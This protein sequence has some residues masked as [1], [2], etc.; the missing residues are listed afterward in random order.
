MKQEVRFNA[1][2]AHSSVH[3]MPGMWRHPRDTSLEHKTIEYWQKLARVLENG[4]FDAIF[5]ADAIGVN[6]VHGG[7]LDTAIRYGLRLPRHDPW[8]L[9]PA[10]AAVTEH[11][12]FGITGTLSYEEPYLF[13]RK[14]STLDHLTR[15]RIAWN[16]VTGYLESG[17]KAMGRTGMMGHD[18][19][20]DIAD[21]F[22]DVV[23][24]LWE[25]SWEDG[26]LKADRATGMFSDPSKVHR[27]SHKGQYYTMDGTHMVDP[28]P[29]RTPV[30]YQAGASGRGRRFAAAHAESVFMIGQT[31]ESLAEI[32]TDV[33]G[34]AANLGR[35]PME[36]SFL[37][38]AIIIVGETEAAA[39]AK[40]AEYNEYLDLNALL[41]LISGTTGVDLSKYD[42]DGPYPDTKVDSSAHTLV[43]AN[44]RSA[45]GRVPTIRE[46]VQRSAFGRGPVI[47]GS[48]TQVA[49]QVQHWV[50]KTGVTGFNLI[51]AVMPGDFEDI[52][53]LLV[54]E[55]QRRGVYKR[56]YRP[57]TLRQKLQNTDASFL[58]ASHPAARQRVVAHA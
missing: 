39:K 12:G 18:L 38:S 31:E 23:Y 34:Q 22:M 24:K 42:I 56:E 45:S 49:D 48:P 51:Y 33:R 10:M 35:D 4:K 16:I 43:D 13:A 5:L 6:D 17:A 54:P 3:Q 40:V 25:G 1:F 21:E 32:V 29:Q 7:S 47:V 20:Y 30:L 50:E 15:G 28:S 53:R 14:L 55:L 37:M 44:T 36:I 8:M 27:I 11:L 41:A 26:A 52:A 19:R 2:L 46:V 9:V 58:P 57:G